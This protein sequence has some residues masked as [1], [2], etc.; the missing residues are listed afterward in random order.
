[1]TLMTERTS[2][3]TQQKLSYNVLLEVH[4]FPIKLTEVLLNLKGMLLVQRKS[5]NQSHKMSHVP[6]LM[7]NSNI[8][9]M[10][11]E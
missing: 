1:M 3:M 9:N 11:S 2:F 4:H 7:K 8:T 6:H 5:Q 10:S